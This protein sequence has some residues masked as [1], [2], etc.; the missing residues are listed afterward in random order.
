SPA[1]VG[2]A[3]ARRSARRAG[4]TEVHFLPVEGHRE[5]TPNDQV[6]ERKPPGPPMRP[7][8]L[9]GR[10]RG[11][12]RGVSTYDVR[13]WSVREYKGRYRKTGNDRSTWRVRWEVA[14]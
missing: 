11:R 7:G 12:D 3:D 10:P 2:T 1:P 14:G 13:I 5:G 9:A 8:R 6:P 4:R